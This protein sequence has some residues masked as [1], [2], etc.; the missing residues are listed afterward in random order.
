MG[1][2]CTNKIKKFKK[3]NR[4][5]FACLPLVKK[6]ENP[7][8]KKTRRN[9]FGSDTWVKKAKCLTQKYCVWHLVK[10]IK[11]PEKNRQVFACLT[12]VK[13]L[14]THPKKK[15][16]VRHLAIFLGQTLVRKPSVWPKNIAKCLTLVQKNWKKKT[17]KC[18]RVWHL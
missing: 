12:L 4:Q 8:K 6:I 14:K 15:T 9:I 5:V 2:T 3:K 11:N 10:K 7:S 18:L 13:K 17:D 1:N 16:S